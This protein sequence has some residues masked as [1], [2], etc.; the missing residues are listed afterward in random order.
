MSWMPPPTGHSIHSA[1]RTL[2]YSM[3][4]ICTVLSGT[5][6]FT[7]G[8]REIDALLGETTLSKM[9]CPVWKVLHQNEEREAKGSKVFH[10]RVDPI[11]EDN[12]CAGK[13]T[14][15]NKSYLPFQE[16]RKIYQMHQVPLRIQFTQMTLTHHL[17]RT[18]TK[19][20]WKQVQR[21]R[22][23]PATGSQWIYLKFYRCL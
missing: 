22:R 14:R 10:F 20:D 8:K 6:Y 11:S 12:S 4:T 13:Q 23:T 9:V 19:S 5:S 17:K 2:F 7:F 3:K 18:P 15:R 1:I 16:W 21:Y